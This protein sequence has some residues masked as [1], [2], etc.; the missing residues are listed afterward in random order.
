MFKKLHS[1]ESLDLNDIQKGWS[2]APS[3]KRATSHDS[4]RVL[5]DDDKRLFIIGR[6]SEDL[7][8]DGQ[9]W[10][11][12]KDT[13]G[14]QPRSWNLKM[15]TRFKITDEARNMIKKSRLARLRRRAER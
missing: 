5:N 1:V 9:D 13:K 6:G 15:A 10:C 11:E 3:V 2:H 7:I 8:F 14:Q 4:S 12:V